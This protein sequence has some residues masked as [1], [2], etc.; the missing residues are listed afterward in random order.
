MRDSY[1][2]DPE[3]LPQA[4]A[5]LKYAF[6]E[7]HKLRERASDL[8]QNP[9]GQGDDEVSLNSGTQLSRIAGDPSK[10]S[11]IHTI[12][13]YQDAIASTIDKFEQMLAAYLNLEDVNQIPEFEVTPTSHSTSPTY[14]ERLQENLGR[15]PGNGNLAV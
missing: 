4:I 12:N 2:V 13:A 14:E 11:L 5:D 3:L 10:G 15:L 1:E 6:I 7:L 9:P 8:A